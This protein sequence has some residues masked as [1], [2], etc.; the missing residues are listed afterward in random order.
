MIASA[1]PRCHRFSSS[2]AVFSVMVTSHEPTR[3]TSPDPHIS[4]EIALTF[5]VPPF[6]FFMPKVEDKKAI[7]A[8]CRAAMSKASKVLKDMTALFAKVSKRK[9]VPDVA[10]RIISNFKNNAHINADPWRGP[11]EDDGSAEV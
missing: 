8:T 5:R 1:Q 2:T 7:D 3:N 4:K 9:N 10:V 6:N 11:Q